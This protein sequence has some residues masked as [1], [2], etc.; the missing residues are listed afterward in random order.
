MNNDFIKNL[1]E[2]IQ[3]IKQDFEENINNTNNISDIEN[4]KI[5]FLG[6]KSSINQFFSQLKNCEEEQKKEAGAL[7]NN[8]RLLLE[9]K[10]NNIKTNLENITL[11]NRLVSDK[12]DITTPVRPYNIG[13]IHII[14]KTIKEIKD[15]FN[16][17]GFTF[18]EGLEIDDDFHN[19]TALNIPKHHP[20]R[21]M[22]DSFYLKN[23]DKL[24]RTHTS[25]VQI[26]QMKNNKP[27]FK[28][29]ALGKVFRCDSDQTHTPMFHQLEGFMVDKEVTFGNLKWILEHFLQEFFAIKNLELRLRPSFFPFTEP[30]AEVDIG[31][32]IDNG[33]IKIGS[34][35]KFLEILG[36]GM[37]N[38]KVLENCNIDSSYQGFAFGI[39]VERLAMLK[40]GAN[41][42]RMFFDNDIR[43]LEHYG[44]KTFQF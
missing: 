33:A 2:Q 35:E 31:Y 41:D 4:L 9:D 12:I 5:K 39:G 23:S 43:F 8:F 3:E 15:I 16:K 10:I 29:A 14:S 1:N 26:H 13:N 11:N 30:S 27:P 21:Q 17:L 25:N 24:L 37:I 20:A 40:Y 28:I 42:L 7:I 19:F 34:S 32:K 18:C 36:C 44:F 6:K 22:Q 38:R